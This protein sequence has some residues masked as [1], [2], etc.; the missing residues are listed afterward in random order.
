MRF[1]E[2]VRLLA[3]D[4]S[5]QI[6]ILRPIPE[7]S[8]DRDFALPN[9]VSRMAELYEAAFAPWDAES[10]ADWIARTELPPELAL[11]REQPFW[12]AARRLRTAIVLI[13]GC[14]SPFLFTAHGLRN[15]PEW[16]LIRHLAIETCDAGGWSLA[17]I[18]TAFPRLWGTLGAGLDDP[19]L[20]R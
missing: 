1:A 19:G 15:A 8:G 11:Q 12:D 6:Q 5:T 13:Q 9:A 4:A 14:D 17:L 20:H 18:E 3:A 16:A 10:V 7:T 2:M